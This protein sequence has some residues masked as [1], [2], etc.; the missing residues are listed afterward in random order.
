MYCC[1]HWGHCMRLPLQSSRVGW[2]HD[3][4]QRQHPAS[5]C[6]HHVVPEACQGFGIKARHAQRCALHAIVTAQKLYMANAQSPPFLRDKR[7]GPLATCHVVSPVSSR[8]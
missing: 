6:P 7:A 5:R 1:C 4:R 2:E 8:V 3:V